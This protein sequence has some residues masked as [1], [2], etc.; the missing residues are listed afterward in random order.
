MSKHKHSPLPTSQRCM[1]CDETPATYHYGGICCSGCKGFFRRSVRFERAYTCSYE[2]KCE[3]LNELRNKCRACRFRRCLDVGLKPKLV[4][5]D[6][7][8]TLSHASSTSPPKEKEFIPST[9]FNTKIQM[10]PPNIP[11]I[12]NPHG[13]NVVNVPI[14][15]IPVVD[16]QQ[17]ETLR[18]ERNLLVNNPNAPL[19]TFNSIASKDMSTPIG[20]AEYFMLVEKMCDMY[21]DCNI[22]HHTSEFAQS[23]SLNVPQRLG[24]HEPR[25]ISQRSPIN[26][27][28]QV[29]TSSQY[30]SQNWCRNTVHYIDWASC[31][32]E[33]KQLS[34]KD[35]EIMLLSRC[36]SSVFLLFGHRSHKM[37]VPGIALGG[38]TYFPTNQEEWNYVD[39]DI[40]MLMANSSGIMS[41]YIQQIGQLKMTDAEFALLRVISFF[42]I[43]EQSLTP[44]G[45]AI[46]KSARNKYLE[47]LNQLVYAINGSLGVL[48]IMNRIGQF[49]LII[50]DIE[51]VYLRVLQA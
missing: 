11:R 18:I 13:V 9:P 6:R 28:P 3:V 35:R 1:V 22:P 43:G 15:P 45:M 37:N 7:G 27:A 51:E 23:C 21:V 46:V 39:K 5:G 34:E 25:L 42:M 40:V 16:M 26:W 14:D 10:V 12:E 24:F 33:V 48:G 44:E 50:S 4:H 49:M 36:V 38:G 47:C 2:N 20:I 8:V 30:Y 32:P 17:L 19:G 29:Y 41:S 31:I